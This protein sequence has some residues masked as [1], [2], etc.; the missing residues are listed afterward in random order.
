LSF[1]RKFLVAE[2]LSGPK[3]S[4][5]AGSV[6]ELAN[7]PFQQPYYLGLEYFLTQP[8]EMESKTHSCRLMDRKNKG[9][10]IS[11]KY[12]KSLELAGET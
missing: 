9:S 12:L 1:D 8:V 3:D 7:H 5:F 2:K 6:S 4:E 11:C 10:N